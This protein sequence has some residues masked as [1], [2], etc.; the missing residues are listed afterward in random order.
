MGDNSGI[1]HLLSDLKN[2][3]RFQANVARWHVEGAQAPERVEP[4]PGLDAG[5]RAALAARGIDR[6]YSHQAQAIE[7]ALAGRHT[8]IVTPTAS[9]K[10][11]CYNLPVLQRMRTRPGARAL[12]L[13]PTK[14]LSQDQVAE[15]SD[16]VRA[17]GDEFKTYTYD[18]DTPGDARRILRESG[19]IIVTNPYMLHGGILPN[20]PK[21]TNLFQNLAYVVIDELHTYRGV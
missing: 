2:D 7:H 6:L 9:G 14:A 11:L 15:L 12:Y 8:A 17:L 18:G 13:F 19:H 20:H 3:A 4:P 10:T 16:L 21:W 5:V 1:E